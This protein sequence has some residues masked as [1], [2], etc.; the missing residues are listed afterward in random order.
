MPWTPLN[1]NIPDFHI[2]NWDAVFPDRHP[3]F[4]SMDARRMKGHATSYGKY[5]GYQQLG[6]GMS[7]DELAETVEKLGMTR[8]VINT[9]L[10]RVVIGDLMLAWIPR[11]EY[12]RRFREKLTAAEERINR[13]IDRHLASQRTKGIKPIVMETEELEDRRAFAA[14]ESDNRVGY[15]SRA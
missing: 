7:A 13:S 2:P 6:A 8:D 11:E 15:G 3:R 5:P 4:I 9:A 1:E 10:N 14:R 12:E